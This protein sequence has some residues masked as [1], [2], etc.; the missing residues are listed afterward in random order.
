MPGTVTITV[1]ICT[2]NPNPEILR[3]CLAALRAQRNV[4]SS[5]E[6]IVVDNSSLPPVTV[7]S[8]FSV[9]PGFNATR[10]VREETLGLTHARHRALQEATGEIVVFVDDDNFL[11]PDYLA[12]VAQFFTDH[13]QAG[14]AGGRCLGEYESPPPAWIASVAAYLAI[15]DQGNQAFHMTQ[16]GWW[17]PVGAGMAVRRQAAL[18]AFA[19]PMLLTDRQ[20][21]SLSSGGDTEI[22]YR[23][24]RAGHQLWYVPT[25]NLEHFMPVWRIEPAYLLKLAEGIGQSQAILEIYRLPDER[26]GP[27][28]ALRRAIYFARQ[29]LV[30]KWRAL[31]ATEEGERISAQIQATHLLTQAGSL[32]GLCFHLPRV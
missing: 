6:L 13:P 16:P 32:F 12:V 11:A 28:L 2:H 15:S 21:K 30:Y 19:K 1:A 29:G 8:E 31:R 27:L 26:R 17:A 18:Q 10:V 9:L 22:C 14:A 3:R 5:T 25:L 20:G 4:P 23:L 24:C 7:P